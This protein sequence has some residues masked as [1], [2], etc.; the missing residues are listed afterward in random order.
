MSLVTASSVSTTSSG[1]QGAKTFTP[2]VSALR[3]HRT[4]RQADRLLDQFAER[5]TVKDY[6][7]EGGDG[8]LFATLVQLPHWPADTAISVVDELGHE[9]AF[10]LKGDDGQVVQHEVA[11]VLHDDGT[12]S[13]GS[14]V[15][16]P[17]ET[18]FR[19]L[20]IQLQPPFEPDADG[21][22]I[23]APNWIAALRAQIVALVRSRRAQLFEALVADA[24]R[25]KSDSLGAPANP[26]LPFWTRT[27]EDWSPALWALH[28]LDPQ[29]PV[30]RLQN[31][32]RTLPLT[33]VEENQLL[34]DDKLPAAHAEALHVSRAE[35]SRDRAIDGLRHMRTFDTQTDTLAR[36][37]AARLLQARLGRNMVITEHGDGRYRPTEPDDNPVA[38]IN[39]GEG[40]YGRGDRNV[41]TVAPAGTTTD[42]FY[43]AIMTQL[44]PDEL[45]SLGL[46]SESDI[47]G[48]RVALAKLAINDNGGWFEFDSTEIIRTLTP[49]WLKRLAGADKKQWRNARRAYSQA[50]FDAQGAERFA[51]EAFGEPTQVREYARY[52]LRERLLVDHGLMLEPDAVI[53]LTRDALA[54]VV[55]SSLAGASIGLIPSTHAYKLTDLSLSNIGYLDFDFKNTAK[56]V[57]GE[58]RPIPAL[59]ASS[60]YDLVRD[61]NVGAGYTA[62]VRSRLLTSEQGQSDTV[63]YAQVMQAQMRLD[64]LEAKFAGDYR[65]VGESPAGQESRGYNWVKT[66]VNSPV[67]DGQRTRVDDQRIQVESL[68]IND[69]TLAGV[70]IIRPASH[71]FGSPLVV[72]TP[73]AWDGRC[74][75]QLNNLEELQPIVRDPKYLDYLTSLAPIKSQTKIKD[76]L[77][78]SFHTLSIDTRVC[79]E[80]FL[81]ADYNAQV[82]RVIESIDQQTTTTSEKNWENAWEIIRTAGEVGLMFTPFKITLPIAALRSLYALVQGVRAASGGDR[83]QAEAYFL[84]A[85][86]LL[87]E[88]YPGPGGRRRPK[89]IQPAPDKPFIDRHTGILN[90]DARPSLP[91]MPDGLTL[92]SDGF[93]NG[94]HQRTSNGQSTFYVLHDGKAYPVEPDHTNKVWR[95]IDL[96]N[97]TARDKT[98]IF[99]DSKN[100][101][102]YHP[103]GGAGG[104]VFKLDL[105]G[106]EQS[107][108]FRK[109]K[110]STQEHLLKVFR[111]IEADFAETNRVHGF[112]PVAKVRSVVRPGASE[113]QYTF[114]VTGMG[115]GGGRGAW[116]LKVREPA[117]NKG[118]LVFEEL[119][120]DH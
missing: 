30:E 66:I 71:F 105:T 98:P 82:N 99:P 18:L 87:L 111:T 28:V 53:V 44:Q 107:K 39:G 25:S 65:Q 88:M 83:K 74:F 101:W 27:P 57:N 34:H 62:L 81:V 48:L 37:L 38:L 56:I 49:G 42:S 4:R 95:M 104:G 90:F 33:P 116:R 97:P 20:Y 24:H 68:L 7:P 113:K 15:V 93:F 73:R 52:K 91:N 64:A 86:F 89:T 85:A 36:A 45:S 41:V 32:L 109:E 55:K 11:L 63:R 80:N 100:A 102:R 9:L 5:F 119:M 6:F 14:A 2:S 78:S 16:A 110:P 108:V 75:R 72:Y 23:G 13:G 94:V 50:V 77:A 96:R 69:V 29:M 46:E 58:G 60:I 22:Y 19:Q 106:V 3:E 92:R 31:L 51:S 115:G 117:N 43:L 40:I 84:E 1:T 47:S 70:L 112:H 79:S 59:T 118:V 26:F 76:S 54:G 10:Y 8:L 12:Y 35:W 61:L 120:D 103:P 67:D 21:F 114:D 17:D